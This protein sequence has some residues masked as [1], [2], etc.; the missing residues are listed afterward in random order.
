MRVFTVALILTILGS[1]Y[2]PV[3][4]AQ[5]SDPGRSTVERNKALATGFYEDLWFN[6]RTD[7]Y[8]EYMADTYVAHDIGERKGVNEPAAMQ[9]TIADGFW[10]HGDMSASSIDYQVAEGDLVATRWTWR[11]E[12]TTWFGRLLYGS[13]E[14]PIINVFRFEDGEIVELW[15]HRHDIDTSLTKKFVA[16]GLLLGLLIALIPTLYA[17]RLRKR[18]KALTAV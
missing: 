12:P 8:S 1:P 15:N 3:I 7:R 18:L 6:N 5:P 13:I 16:Q 4:Q 17:M 11:Y 14:I 2:A 9:K 10:H